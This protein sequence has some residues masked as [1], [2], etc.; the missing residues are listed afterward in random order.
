MKKVYIFGSSGSGKSTL[1]YSLSH[2]LHLPHI[3][4][5]A[6]HHQPGWT[7]LP[8]SE[9]RTRVGSIVSQERWIIDGAYSA[10]RDLVIAQADTLIFLDYSRSRV[11]FQLLRRTIRRGVLRTELWNGNQERLHKLLSTNPEENIVLWSMQNFKKRRTQ[12]FAIENDLTLPANLRL[13]FNHPRETAAWLES[14]QS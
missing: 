3:E 12:S 11:L 5:D 2:L 13:R 7:S 8:E 6:I 10:V 14:L 4:L 9:F 1:G